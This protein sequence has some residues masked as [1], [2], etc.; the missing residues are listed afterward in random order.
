M[1]DPGELISNSIAVE[2]RSTMETPQEK[3][4]RLE[5]QPLLLSL[6]TTESLAKENVPSHSKHN[7]SDG[8]VELID[9]RIDMILRQREHNINHKDGIDHIENGAGSPEENTSHL[10]KFNSK[11]QI[12]RLL[13]WSLAQIG[14]TVM[15]LSA[16]M[17]SIYHYANKHPISNFEK[18][19]LNVVFVSYSLAVGM[20]VAYTYKRAAVLL[21]WR[22]LTQRV[23]T[24]AECAQVA[25]AVIGLNFSIN[26]DNTI[27]ILNTGMTLLPNMT[28]IHAYG[29]GNVRNQSAMQE[30]VSNSYGRESLRL[31]SNSTVF[32]PVGYYWNNGPCISFDETLQSWKFVFLDSEP[33]GIS[34]STHRGGMPHITLQDV[35][36]NTTLPM[37]VPYAGG[38]DQTTFFTTPD[39]SCGS[40]CGVVNA[41][42]VNEQHAYLYKCN[43][44]VG[45]VIGG[46]I[47]EHE[48]GETFR[49]ISSK[50]IALQGF[51]INVDNT[52]SMQYQVYPHESAFGTPANGSTTSI[53]KLIGRFAIGVIAVSSIYPTATLHV[54]TDNHP[55]VGNILVVES[56]WI[57][58]FTM[59]LLAVV[60]GLVIFSFSIW[61]NRVI[62][63][64]ESPLAMA[65]LLKPILDH[66]NNNTAADSE[67]ICERLDKVLGGQCLVR[68]TVKQKGVGQPFQLAFNNSERV[69]A[70]PEGYYD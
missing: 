48:V 67:K 6:E 44:S 60:P 53:G 58:W 63:R 20:N 1:H 37:E 21:R 3:Q 68:Y 33:T 15:F 56:W 49:D 13:G 64:D 62:V 47:P 52:S 18:K 38:M 25:I 16:Y 66:L 41:Y 12:G 51:G 14:L 17:V 46:L 19:W 43:I 45:T 2:M 69:R 5:P 42:E 27:A 4:P 54:V 24:L 35:D 40:G 55:C 7:V 31:Q 11:Q 70:F 23:R 39:A 26:A 29:I 30:F 9:S 36:D 32:P 50:A 10:F 34:Y 61:A 59:G 65:M 8:L 57:I 22:I 28:E